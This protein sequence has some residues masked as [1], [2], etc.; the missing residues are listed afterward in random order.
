MTTE[1]FRT[2]YYV[3]P[4]QPFTVL[5][6][7]GREFFVARRNHLTIDPT[8]HR[9]VIAP[10]IEDMEMIEITEV[11]GVRSMDEVASGTA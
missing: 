1:D 10:K 11:A 4:F 7:D 9:I 2:L 6:R 3:K 8:G 5:L